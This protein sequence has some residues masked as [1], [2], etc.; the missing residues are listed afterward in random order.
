MKPTLR[1]PGSN[2]RPVLPEWR[3]WC[4]AYR[5]LACVR[6]VAGHGSMRRGA[7]V[8]EDEG[9]GIGAASLGSPQ[10]AKQLFR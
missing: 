2:M 5:A 9:E 1:R 7:A 8:R 10:P 4:D 6:S 3:L